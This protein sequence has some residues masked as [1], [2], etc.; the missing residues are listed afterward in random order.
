MAFILASAAFIPAIRAFVRSEKRRVRAYQL[1][2]NG[3][4]IAPYDK[5]GTGSALP[6]LQPRCRPRLVVRDCR[7]QPLFLRKVEK[8][9]CPVAALLAYS[10]NRNHFHLTFRV[11]ENTSEKESSQASRKVFQSYALAY[12]RQQRRYGTLFQEPYKCA[13]VDTEEYLKNLIRYQHGNPKLH[14]L[15]N[16]FRSWPYT[17]YAQII[18]QEPTILQR[19]AA[20]ELFRGLEGFIR[21]HEARPRLSFGPPSLEDE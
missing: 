20:L 17:S 3:L 5:A 1:P 14:K 6:Y 2:A 18:G 11:Q 12:Y 7:A 4:P 15:V 16:D 10:L 8:Y 19:A 13:M 9:I 21:F